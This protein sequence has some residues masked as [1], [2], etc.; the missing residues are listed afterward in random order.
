MFIRAAIV[1]ALAAFATA[2]PTAGDSKTNNFTA[3]STRS[4]DPNVHLHQIIANGG[5][6][7]LNKKSGADCPSKK[8]IDCSKCKYGPCQ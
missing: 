4:G 6:F 8:D 7:F 2:T 3:I 1:S 5:S